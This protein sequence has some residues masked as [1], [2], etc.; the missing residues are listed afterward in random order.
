M[1]GPAFYR[2][3]S[4]WLDSLA[5]DPLQPRPPLPGS[6]RV[7]VCIVGAGYT[8]LW[9]AYEL[10]KADPSLRI[11]VLDAEIA[12]FG[13]S[14][15]NGGWC[16]A[17]MPMGL[18]HLVE[19]HGREPAQALQAAM[20]ATVGE[21][22]RVAGAEGIDCHFH[23][24]GTL[25]LATNPA[26]SARLHAQLDEA[27]RF[28]LGEDDVRWLDRDEA[29][30]LVHAQGTLG[31]LFTPHCAALHPARLARGLARA[32]EARGVTIHEHT[33]VL[34]IGP[35]VAH[36]DAGNV[37]ADVVVRA[38]EGFTARLAGLRRAIVPVYSLMIAT[39]PLPRSLW[40]EIGW[41]DRMTLNDG[42]NLI[43]YGQRT[44][45]DRIAFGGR[46]AP[47]HFGSATK[48]A[49]DR[50]ERVFAGLRQ[51]LLELFPML[52]GI[53]HTHAWGGPLGVA[54]DWY[55]SVGLDR[56][57]KQAWAGGYVGDGVATSNLAGRTLADLILGRDTDLTRLPWVGHRSPR[58]EPEP[59]RWLGINAA[60]RLPA[61][62][63]RDEARR[64]RS[65]AWRLALLD[66]LTGH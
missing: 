25:T 20:I 50:D 17:L 46:G 54:R 39:E 22:G 58:W 3:R 45:D 23:K 59:L 62:A 48:A 26:H 63:D 1:H 27:R 52:G 66:R 32:V 55:C 2:T 56:A 57:A 10:A 11:V 37:R 4:F 65:S 35:G 44:A 28:G 53:E 38:T 40:E 18:D 9:T 42:R 34:E 14:G 5:G 15:R 43:V 33:P 41:H 29:A 51:V 49:Y 47:Y 31:A 16:S 6:T 12:G 19:L 36:T 7:D 8:G 64:G 21:V 60:L 30:A 13:A 61:G 24:G